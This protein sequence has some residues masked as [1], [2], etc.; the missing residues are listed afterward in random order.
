MVELDPRTEILA[1]IP[2]RS[3]SKSIPNKNV[4]LLSGNPLIS[5]TINAAIKSAMIS[6][7]IVSTDSAE[8]AAISQKSGAET[9]FIRP[10]N[11]SA[12]T[13][14]MNPVLCHALHWLEENQQYIPSHIALLQPTSPF[15]TSADIDQALTIMLKHKAD[16]VVSVRETKHHPYHA[17]S[18]S[19]EG[20][21]STFLPDNV[22][23]SDPNSFHRRQDLPKAYAL[24]GAIYCV[25]SQIMLQ[26][27]TFYTDSTV[28]YLMPEE[29]SLDIDSPWDLHIAELIM[30]NNNNQT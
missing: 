17:K 10:T 22:L 8:I 9:P 3:G 27:G 23:P 29:R 13:T 26:R 16:G 4:Q 24:N 12:D 5:Y 2:A 28:A 11:L 21:I 30:R 18:I 25:R 20:T 1:L 15:R 6:R 19:K 14:T 7:C